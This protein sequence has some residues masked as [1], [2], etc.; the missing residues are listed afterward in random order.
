[1]VASDRT[2]GEKDYAVT[3]SSVPARKRPWLG[4][5]GSMT[6]LECEEEGSF[7]KSWALG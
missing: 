3:S 5:N 6:G 7:G 4:F 1:M 2:V